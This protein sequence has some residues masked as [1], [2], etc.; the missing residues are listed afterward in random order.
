MDKQT[1]ILEAKN[2]FYA[3]NSGPDVIRDVS[4][5]V[6]KGQYISIVGPNGSGKSTLLQLLCGL[7]KPE[8]GQ[9]I[10]DHSNLETISLRQR[11]KQMG[12]IHQRSASEF[13]FRCMDAIL[14]GLHPTRRAFEPINEEQLIKVQQIM[15]VTDTLAFADKLTTEISGG[16]RQRVAFARVFLQHPQILLMDESMSDMDVHAKIEFTKIVKKQVEQDQLTVIAVNHDLN[17]AYRFSDQVLALVDGMVDSYGPPNE[18]MDEA[19]FQRVFQV[20][21][22]VVPEKGCFIYDN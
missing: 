18:V 3:Y 7:Y 4:I 13:P 5:K 17:M 19:F 21:A 12:V 16:E 1:S 15:T 14:M 10:L 9:V 8:N 20:K 22:E 6:P 11:A 2:L